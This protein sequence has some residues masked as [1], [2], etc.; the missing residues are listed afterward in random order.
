MCKSCR[1]EDTLDILEGVLEDDRYDFASEMLTG[2]YEWIE[3]H[4]HVTGKQLSAINNVISSVDNEAWDTFT[5]M[6][7]EDFIDS[8]YDD[9][10]D[11]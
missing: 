1:W 5:T 6:S 11:F 9:G 2:I 7:Y 4:E 3:E 10:G 8:F